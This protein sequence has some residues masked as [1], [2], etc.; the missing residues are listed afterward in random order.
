MAASA[1]DL[2]LEPKLVA[3]AKETFKEEI[4][5]TEYRPLLPPDQKPPLELNRNLMERYRPTMRAHYL[6]KKPVFV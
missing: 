5:D 6:K 4:G 1:I 2:F 3:R